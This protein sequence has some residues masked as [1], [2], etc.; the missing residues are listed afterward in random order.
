MTSILTLLRRALPTLL[1]AASCA[2]Q[3]QNF[4]VRPV[5]VVFPYPAGSPLDAIGRMVIDRAGKNLGQPMVFENKP[6]ANGILGQGIAARAAPDGYTVLLS[7]TSAF[8]LNSFLRK[9]LPYDAERSFVPITAVADIPVALIVSSRLPVNNTR[10]FVQYLKANPT[11][12]NYGSV[13]NGSFNHLLMEQF[14]AAA[15]VDMLHV[16]YQGAGPV[17]TELLAGRIDAAVLAP[18]GPWTPNQV[19]LLAM[20]STKR[21]AAL[22]KVP[23]ITEE[24]P[25][26]RPFGNWMGFFA[27]TGTPEPVVR[28]LSEAFNAALKEPDVRA[29]IEEQQW[30]VIGGSPEEFRK[31]ITSDI[32][33]VGAAFK[34]ANIKPE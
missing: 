29:K 15:G 18:L 30:S 32:A 26:F 13:G 11:R 6:G 1:L 22:P 7:S 14:K 9:D 16:P 17:A 31:T 19:K 34:S 25:S 2:T 21:S 23:A 24:F 20:M 33:T 27:P 10:E 3:A 5:H 8:L 12:V 4:P 28:R